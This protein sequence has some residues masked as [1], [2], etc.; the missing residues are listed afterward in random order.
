MGYHRGRS[1][2]DYGMARIEFEHHAKELAHHPRLPLSRWV[3]AQIV[4]LAIAL[5]LLLAAGSLAPAWAQGRRLALVVGISAFKDKAFQ[6]LRYAASDARQ[7]AAYL[8]DP[9]GG[10][11]NPKDITVLLNEQATKSNILRHI[12]HIVLTSQPE[13]TV[14]VYFSSHGAYTPDHEAGIVCHDSR[15]VAQDWRFGPIVK[16]DTALLRDSLHRFLRYLRAAKRAVVVD[17]CHGA[18]ATAGVSCTLPKLDGYPPESEMEAGPDKNAGPGAGEDQVT[19]VMTSCL[20]RERAW[21]S[22]QLG[23]SIFTYYLIQGLR[24]FEGNLVEAFYY[25]QEW[26]QRQSSNEKGWCQMPYIVTHPPWQRL[27]LGP[28]GKS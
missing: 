13:D 6:T 22:R 11:F 3:L 20:G 28:P 16:P 8:A 7:M 23:A 17:V 25:A 1:C 4:A 21:E 10:C 2:Y 27:I 5:A 18:D 15:S 26:T 12:Q 19:V 14:L 9:K 24:H